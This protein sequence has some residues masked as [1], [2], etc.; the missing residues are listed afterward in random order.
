MTEIDPY[1]KIKEQSGSLATFSWLA[2]GLLFYITSENAYLF[3]LSAAL[4][5]FGGMFLAAIVFGI[6]FYGADRLFAK[7]FVKTLS[8]KVSLENE[9]K[10]ITISGWLLLASK[11]LIVFCAAYYLFKA[12]NT[13]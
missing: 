5:L 10:I 11:I 7:I 9:I 13:L 4:F 8:N 6:A 2:S 3:S 1:D 12:W